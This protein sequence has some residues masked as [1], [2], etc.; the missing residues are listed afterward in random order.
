MHEAFFGSFGVI[1]DRNTSCSINEFLINLR[2]TGS[3]LFHVLVHVRHHSQ[4]LLCQ[5][6]LRIRVTFVVLSLLLSSSRVQ[7]V[8]IWLIR[9]LQTGIGASSTVEHV[10][11][12]L[13]R[14][15]FVS[16]RNTLE[17]LLVVTQL[18]ILFSLEVAT[19]SHVL[20]MVLTLALGSFYLVV[21]R[22]VLIALGLLDDAGV[23]SSQIFGS[24]R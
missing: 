11:S 16:G 14:R 12:F 2:N 9:L 21:N 1:D 10:L 7:S 8:E 24:E 13:G 17:H 20:M 19:L 4:L 3:S 5:I 18:L 23:I 6:S 22:L 15:V